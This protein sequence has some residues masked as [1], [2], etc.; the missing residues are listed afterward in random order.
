MNLRVYSEDLAGD[1]SYSIPLTEGWPS[2][3]QGKLPS[4]TKP[5]QPHQADQPNQPQQS[6]KGKQLQPD[7]S[8]SH[9]QWDDFGGGP[10]WGDWVMSMKA[11]KKW[12]LGPYKDTEESAS[13]LSK[14]VNCKAGWERP[15]ENDHAGNF[16]THTSSLHDLY[17]INLHIMHSL[18]GTW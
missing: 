6:T 2:S 12:D 1:W 17:E 4:S 13:P 11:L 14:M 10:W 5:Q 8:L 16:T 7:H 3:I 15:S 9:S 18:N